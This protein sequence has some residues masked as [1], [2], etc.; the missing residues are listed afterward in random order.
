MLLVFGAVILLPVAT[1]ARTQPTQR[2]PEPVITSGPRLWALAASAFYHG[3]FDR[4][5]PDVRSYSN[6]A[7]TRR[8][9]REWWGIGDRSGLLEDLEW[10]ES[11]GHRLEFQKLGQALV[12]MTDARYKAL[13]SA[14]R[15]PDRVRVMKL[16]REHFREYRGNSAVAWDYGR[17]IALCR[18]GY[19]VGYLTEDEAW[20]R[21]MPAARTIQRSFRSWVEFGEDFIV[22]REFWSPEEMR[23]TGQAFRDREKWLRN[24]PQSP[25]NRLPWRM[26]LGPGAPSRR[27]LPLVRP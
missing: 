22:G 5:S 12:A 4:L 25:W 20:R 21:I 19:M 17:Y 16:T 13:L 3:Y 18:W 27:R 2:A 6:V 9:L 14:E 8:L 10:L 7:E 23:K 24:E 26:E 1:G 11:G 15:N